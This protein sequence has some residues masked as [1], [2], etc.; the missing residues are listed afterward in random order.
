M[1]RMHTESGIF[2]GTNTITVLEGQVGSAFTITQVMVSN[3]DSVAQSPLM[4]IRNVGREGEDD[5]YMHIVPQIE[6]A[7]SHRMVWDDGPVTLRSGQHLEME[8]PADHTTTP[9]QW[10]VI[11]LEDVF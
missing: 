1:I 11:W 9:P 2:D 6:I 5:E 8:L 3:E 10:R 7:S 4:R